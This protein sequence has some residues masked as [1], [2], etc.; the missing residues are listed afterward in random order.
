MGEGWETRRRRR[1]GYDW[2]IVKLGRPGRIRQIEVDTHHFNGNFPEACSIEGLHSSN[3]QL[4]PSDFSTRTDLTWKP[5]LPQTR[6]EG[7]KRHFFGK[8]LD[9]EMRN[10]VFDHIRLNIYPDGGISRLRVFGEI[11]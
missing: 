9:P 3:A 8:E 11:A 7:D 10:H 1:P 6:L 5:L 4:I 2:I